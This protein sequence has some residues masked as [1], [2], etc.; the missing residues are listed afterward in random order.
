MPVS[1]VVAGV[2]SLLLVAVGV[3]ALIGS[4]KGPTKPSLVGKSILPAP[5]FPRVG[6]HG[7]VVAPWAEHHPTVLVFFARWCSVCATEV[8]R[9]TAALRDGDLGNVRVLG[10]DGDTEPGTAAAFVR[11]NRVRFPVG[12]DSGLPFSYALG[13]V[14]YPDAVFVAA[15]GRV[16]GE[17]VGAVSDSQLQA[18]IAELRRS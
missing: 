10:I 18:G 1:L 12:L 11:A 2:L 4:S 3:L 8:P 17:D 6:A 15:S 13:L 14:G 5:R 16:V 7:V 9:L